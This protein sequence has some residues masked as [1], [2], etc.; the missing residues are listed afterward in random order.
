M[1]SAGIYNSYNRKNLL[2]Y[3]IKQASEAGN[4]SEF[5]AGRIPWVAYSF[6]F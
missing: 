3:R 5:A 2:F 4:L 6:K 1:F